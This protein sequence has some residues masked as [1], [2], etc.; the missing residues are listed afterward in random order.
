MY[1]PGV[2]GFPLEPWANLAA[3]GRALVRNFCI[4]TRS[5]Q[6]KYVLIHSSLRKTPTL[7]TTLIIL[8]A[9]I[10]FSSKHLLSGIMKLYHLQYNL[11]LQNPV[12]VRVPWPVSISSR[13]LSSGFLANHTI[14]WSVIWENSSK[15]FLIYNRFFEPTSTFQVDFK[16]NL[17]IW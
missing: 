12:T 13:Q 17:I 1:L 16:M 4:S 2:R 10:G 7:G 3:F 8:C 9:K 6:E 14:V 11:L 15:L 5:R